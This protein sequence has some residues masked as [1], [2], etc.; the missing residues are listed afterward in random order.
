MTCRKQPHVGSRIQLLT[1]TFH[2]HSR[3]P[4]YVPL[5][6]ACLPPKSSS[7]TAKEVF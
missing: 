3:V 6:L 7:K 5:S 1:S 2:S 4:C